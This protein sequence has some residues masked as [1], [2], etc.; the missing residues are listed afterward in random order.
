MYSVSTISVSLTTT[1]LFTRHIVIYTFHL[2]HNSITENSVISSLHST[3]KPH[4]TCISSEHN[5]AG[6]Y[7]SPPAPQP[8]QRQHHQ[9]TT[10]PPSPPPQHLTNTTTIQHHLDHRTPTHQ[11]THPARRLCVSWPPPARWCTYTL[12]GHVWA[13]GRPMTSLPGWAGA[14]L[15]ALV[16]LAG[17]CRGGQGCTDW[18]LPLPASPPS[19]RPLPPPPPWPRQCFRMLGTFTHDML[20]AL[21]T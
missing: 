11:H 14:W 13:A 2:R 20:V 15:V 6:F 3:T 5:D 19:P 16:W 4:L 1:F 12:P 7:E 18:F 17:R 21:Y 10:N 9:S 8:P